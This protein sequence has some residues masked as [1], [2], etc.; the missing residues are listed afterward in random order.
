MFS[1][2]F[3][4]GPSCR[5]VLWPYFGKLK[6]VIKEFCKLGMTLLLIGNPLPNTCLSFLSKKVMMFSLVTV[7]TVWA[8]NEGPVIIVPNMNWRIRLMNGQT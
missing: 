3:R 6:R 2:I 8:V 7:F 4:V 5:N 1:R